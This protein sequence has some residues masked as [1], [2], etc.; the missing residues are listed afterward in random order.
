MTA[1]LYKREITPPV[2]KFR[3]IYFLHT[4]GHSA[5]ALFCRF[6]GLLFGQIDKILT[7]LIFPHGFGLLQ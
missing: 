4:S 6:T 1:S 5:I 2:F 3:Q 7:V